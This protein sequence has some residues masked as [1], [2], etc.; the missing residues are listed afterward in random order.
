MTVQ[1]KIVWTFEAM[2]G[3]VDAEVVCESTPDEICRTKPSHLSGCEC[4][5]FFDIG[6][7]ERGWFHVVETESDDGRETKYIHRHEASDDCNIA[8]FMNEDPM[9]TILEAAADR[10]TT[11]VIGSTPFEP[12]WN[13]NGYDWKPVADRDPT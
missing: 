5:E 8:L 12:E 2:M 10:S 11:L 6:R 3:R 4:E 9:D 1:H 7:D 13:G